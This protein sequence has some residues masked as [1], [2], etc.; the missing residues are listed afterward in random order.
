M[1]GA[2]ASIVAAWVKY[3]ESRITKR[4]TVYLGNLLLQSFPRQALVLA[5]AVRQMDEEKRSGAT[6]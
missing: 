4:T 6:L 3:A 2:L 1:L 5:D